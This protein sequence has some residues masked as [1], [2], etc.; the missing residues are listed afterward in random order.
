MFLDS[1][2]EDINNRLGSQCPKA[3]GRQLDI[4]PFIGFRRSALDGHI[5]FLAL[6]VQENTLRIFC[7][8]ERIKKFTEKI[9]VVELGPTND[10]IAQEIADTTRR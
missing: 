2:T 6:K 5:C 9:C 4:N 1:V 7:G 8:V 3:S 10:R